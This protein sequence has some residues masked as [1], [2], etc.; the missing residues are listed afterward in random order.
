MKLS[1]IVPVYGVEKYILEFAQSLIFQ[2]NDD[3][4]LIVIN[5]GTKDKSITLF[6]EYV[7]QFADIN[8]IWLEQE[9]QGQSV[10]RN[11]GIS[12]AQ[13]DYVT[14]LD[15]DDYVE[16]NYIH[17]I[18]EAMNCKPDIVQFNAYVL[19]DNKVKKNIQLVDFTDAGM[20]INNKKYINVIYN[21]EI[22]FCWLRVF[23][24]D[25]L[26]ENYFEKGVNFQDMMAIPETYKKAKKIYNLNE[27]LIFYRVHEK[28]SV[29]NASDKL[30]KSALVGLSKFK[31]SEDEGRIIYNGFLRIFI[32]YNSL[33]NGFFKQI[34][35]FIKNYK[36]FRIRLFPNIFLYIMV[37]NLKAILK[38]MLK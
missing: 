15:P 18:F 23:K 9:N 1:V 10:A 6:K 37:Y 5:D 7:T 31:D 20:K 2:L 12:V 24:K 17:K 26:N 29:H 3:V 35:I 11:Y 22:W 25:F 36:L 8:I 19:K 33:V 14:F 13:G 34:L 27:N 16:R 28:S 30:I 4:E 32:E 38:R 21:K